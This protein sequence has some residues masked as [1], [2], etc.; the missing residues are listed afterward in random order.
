MCELLLEYTLMWHLGKR[1]PISAAK[2]S[3]NIASVKVQCISIILCVS[4]S[5]VV[6]VAST[7]VAAL[8]FGSVDFSAYDLYCLFHLFQVQ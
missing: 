5:L 7:C 8:S 2:I 6:N 3:L 4:I 1:Q